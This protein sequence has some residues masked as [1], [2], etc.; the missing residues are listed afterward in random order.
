MAEIDAKHLKQVPNLWSVTRK[1]GKS[2]LVYARDDNEAL[3]K[4]NRLVRLCPELEFPEET[5]EAV[6]SVA[7]VV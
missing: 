1:T 5:T 2:T 4:Y 6:R 3:A 7:A